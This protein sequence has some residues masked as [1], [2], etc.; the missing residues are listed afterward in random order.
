M[1]YSDTASGET[2]RCW[3]HAAIGDECTIL[4]HF[5]KARAARTSSA[6]HRRRLLVLLDAD[7]STRSMCWIAQPSTPSKSP[8]HVDLSNPDTSR[9]SACLKRWFAEA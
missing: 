2:W 6:R 4:V 1:A 9:S 7:E 5:D 3:S 8:R